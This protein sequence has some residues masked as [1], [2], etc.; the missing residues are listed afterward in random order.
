MSIRSSFIGAATSLVL[1]AASSPASAVTF[2]VT[3][4]TIQAG[5]T[6]TLD[7]AVTLG[8]APPGGAIG[9]Q[10]LV[11]TLFSDL[12]AGT[13]VTHTLSTTTPTQQFSSTFTFPNPGTFHPSYSAAYSFFV[14]TPIVTEQDGQ[15]R[16]D[17]RMDV[18]SI[19][20]FDSEPLTVNANVAAVPIPAALPLFA[21]G[22]GVMAWMARRRRS[23]AAHA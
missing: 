2:T 22:L 16:I 9:W 6:S 18:F 4:G 20:S 15:V 13:S 7:F 12:F 5:E 17:Y 11:L 19:Q 8:A 10:S 21:G 1:L 23:Q 14:T 3:P